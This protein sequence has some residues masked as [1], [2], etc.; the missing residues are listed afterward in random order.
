MKAR[1]ATIAVVSL[2]LG[3]SA[4]SVGGRHYADSKASQKAPD[5]PAKAKSQESPAS[6]FLPVPTEKQDLPPLEGDGLAK[7]LRALA[8]MENDADRIQGVFD[9]VSRFKPEDWKRALS[10]E[11]LRIWSKPGRPEPGGVEQLLVAAWTEADPDAAM[12]WAKARGFRGF[13]VTTAWIGKD[14]DALLDYFKRTFKN[15]NNGNVTPMIGKA[16]EALGNDLPRIARAIREVPEEWKDYV[17]LHA[18]PTFKNLTMAEMRP[19]VDS[20]DPPF[21][22]QGFHLLL[23]GL[24]GHEARLSLLREFPDLVEPWSSH[25]V[26]HEWVKSD[27]P[28]AL[29]S[30][31]E[32]AP[33]KTRESALRGA[34]G[35]LARQDDLSLLFSTMRRYS[36]EIP[37]ERMAGLIAGAVDNDNNRS[38][39]MFIP[40][41]FE[42]P[43]TPRPTS[44]NAAIALAEVPRIQSEELRAQLYRHVI[45]GWMVED[46]AAA[47]KWL[48]QNELPEGMRKEFE[49]G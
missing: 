46:R 10:N 47:K 22:T 40:D 18:R 38:G 12:E 16:I 4:L 8:A 41:E 45:T 11:C 32:I 48:E 19:F 2:L 33:G 20:L 9:L 35:G 34:L 13:M 28:G 30:L 27:L 42:K 14:P 43:E 26:Y 44:G 36:D 37:E 31:E 21:K 39:S 6:S 25:A 17:T 3:M 7:Q 23:A 49:D 1:T 29:K 15:D 24:P 5:R